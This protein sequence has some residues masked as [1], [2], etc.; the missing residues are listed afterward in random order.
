MVRDAFTNTVGQ[1]TGE[2]VVLPQGLYA[3]VV[4]EKN[5]RSLV[6]KELGISA[7]AKIV[8]G[9]GY[10]DLRKGIDL[11]LET[12]RRALANDP[13]LVFVWVGRLERSVSTWLMG[14]DETSGFA[15][16][17]RTVD[18]T[19]KIGRYL[20]AA[21]AFYLTSREDPFPSTVLEALAF[22]LPVVGFAGKTGSEEIISRF[23]QIVPPYDTDQALSALTRLIKANSI[24]TV[25][26]RQAVIAADFRW[27]RYAF[28]LLQLLD[29]S[30]KQISV[31]IPNFNYANYLTE[32]LES[33][34]GQ[35][36]PIFEIVVFDDASTDRSIAVLDDLAK[37][38]KR[39]FKVI[40]KS[41]NSKSIMAQWA[42]AAEDTSGEYLWI[43]EADD[44]ALPGFVQELVAGTSDATILIFSDSSQIDG[45][46]NALAPS[47]DY[48][49]ERFHGKVF[50][51]SFVCSGSE[52]AVKYL[53]TSNI[54]LNVSA[55]LF[56]REVLRETLNADL[57]E[58][59][60][61]RFAGD[62]AVYLRLCKHPG[63]I[64]YVSRP[65]NI[66][67]RHGGSVTHMTS[68]ADHVDE[69]E[70]VHK[71]SRDL[72]DRGATVLECQ[73]VYLS[74]IRKQFSLSTNEN[75]GDR[76]A[77]PSN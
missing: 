16:N 62:W 50:K 52:F 66:H 9:V 12:A 68:K 58:L 30:L 64:A 21:D 19:D 57:K 49:F 11:F 63:E 20:G 27:D 53:T 31:A 42:K 47:Y 72:F 3:D 73:K 5:C 6:R 38:S 10:A 74:E 40:K 33:V 28:R 14:Q 39:D 48:Y 60:S 69:I 22:G 77:P 70:R 29:P 4:H 36:Y 17:V 65:L 23:G 44:L 61:Y 67:R 35:N 15:K 7:T 1:V 45:E 43:A 75:D 71:I 13:D 34:F 46:G 41:V 18:F 55:V 24:E 56:R 2:A 26:E 51:K 37:N 54:I 25:R 32:R 76:Q 59:R 8:L